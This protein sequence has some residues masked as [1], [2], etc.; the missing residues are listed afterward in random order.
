[1]ARKKNTLTTEEVTVKTEPK[2]G[3]AKTTPQ[4]PVRYKRKMTDTVTV[5]ECSVCHHTMW[6]ELPK[7]PEC[8]AEFVKTEV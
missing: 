5:Y 4:D 1:M 6:G 8:G 3:R 7:C 2:S